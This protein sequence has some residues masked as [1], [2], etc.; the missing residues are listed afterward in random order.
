MSTEHVPAGIRDSIRAV[1]PRETAL[2]IRAAVGTYDAYGDT[3]DIL[4]SSQ[5]E[6]I[7]RVRKMALQDTI[8]GDDLERADP[9][10]LISA[11]ITAVELYDIHGESE[12]VRLADGEIEISDI[13]AA[14]EHARPL[15][16][17]GDQDE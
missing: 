5:V 12:P 17:D 1:G 11:M 2:L 3:H 6:T 7:E 10:D 8:T 4:S 9:W 13:A 14:I 15:V 16:M